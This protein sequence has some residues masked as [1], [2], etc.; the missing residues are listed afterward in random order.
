MAQGFES[1]AM[2]PQ[3]CFVS[4]EGAPE[5]NELSETTMDEG[6]LTMGENGG[7]TVKAGRYTGDYCMKFR[8]PQQ[9]M[10]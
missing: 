9:G 1:H 8:E 4:R 3:L 2:E 6:S 10:W 5:E 7:Q